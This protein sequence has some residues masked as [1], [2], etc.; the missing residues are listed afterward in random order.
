MNL[1][2]ICLNMI[3]K[4]E[5][6]IIERLLSSVID[7]IDTFC[8]EDTGSTD[9]TIELIQSFFSK[10][11]IFGKIVSE[12]FKNFAYNRTH[13]L[14]AAAGLSDYLLFID[15]DMILEK[16]IT[17]AQL[18]QKLQTHD[19]FYVFQGS[20]TFNYKNVRFAKNNLKSKYITPTH[21]YFA[22]PPN[23]TY[24]TFEKNELFIDDRGDGGSKQ[25]KAERDIRLLTEQLNIT[26]NDERCLF[27]LANSYRDN[28][29][30]EKAIENYK[31]RVEV[32]GW[33][34]E[35]WSSLYNI[36]NIYYKRNEIEKAIYYWLEGY[37]KFSKRIE[38]LYEIIKHY[39]LK[40]NN[41]LAYYFIVLAD[42]ERTQN[43]K[44]DYLFT[45]R[46]VYEYKLD[47]ELSIVGYYCNTENYDLEKVSMKVISHPCVNDLI[48]KNVLMNY[49]FYA[50][51]MVNQYAISLPKYNVNLLKKMEDLSNTN[52]LDTDFVSSTPSICQLNKNEIIVCTRHVNYRIDNNGGYV[53]KN[54]IITHNVLSKIDISN[55]KWEYITQPQILEYNTE[56]NS[57]YV[58]LE[59]VRLIVNNNEIY[60]NANRGIG[61]NEM[62][63]E[64]GSILLT[65]DTCKIQ[66]S[67]ILKKEKEN[68]I[69]KNWVLFNS[70]LPS[71]KCTNNAE[72]QSTAH[73]K[74]V[75]KWSPLTVGNICENGIFKETHI[76]NEVP[77]FFS[78]LRGS[79]NGVNIANEIWFLCHIVSY[80]DRRY[81]YHIFV[82]LDA[83]T[84]K[85]KK[86]TTLFTFH[87]EKVEYSLGFIYLPSDEKLL[88]GYSIM[89]KET[90]YVQFNKTTFDDIMI[91]VKQ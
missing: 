67:I 31:K 91:I 48:T 63:I 46:D 58:G 84:F 9:N 34:E 64:H 66:K 78:N 79:T 18:K 86:Y 30:D 55:E 4:N 17:K 1:P 12:P 39:R 54:H 77:T 83:I 56:L 7:I 57:R 53:N 3:V 13:A 51:D 24:G 16:K 33:I 19:I 41:Q 2:T 15:S 43:K 61:N 28:N 90:R 80:E 72:N 87:K 27:Y 68:L 22:P 26:P 42:K 47:Y 35:Q 65:S 71:I 40:G 60:Y 32:G 44:W 50:T 52:C 45:H 20:Q 5:S 8:I 6:H 29:E 70:F 49:K 37:N 74:C 81:Y 25:N 76:Y 89:D 62:K 82:V 21:E 88:I 36:G 73:I 59:D 11:G 14:E 75:Y 85:L 10:K 38:N 69:E 23:C